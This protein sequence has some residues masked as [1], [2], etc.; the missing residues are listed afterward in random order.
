MKFKHLALCPVFLLLVACSNAPHRAK[1]SLAQQTT[2]PEQ[3]QEQ[4]VANDDAVNGKLTD[5][6]PLAE[7]QQLVDSGL[8]ANPNL[9]QTA[10]ALSIAQA[11][12]DVSRAGQLPQLELSLKQ[13][14]Q[15]QQA[16]SYSAGLSL[17]WTVDIWQQLRDNKL[18]SKAQLAGAAATYQGARDL[19]AAN[20]ING[21]LLLIKEQQLIETE[22]AKLQV[23]E[24]NEQA[25][26]ERYRQGL[27]TLSE[28]DTARSNTES[29]RA[30]LVALTENLQVAKR[31]LKLLLGGKLPELSL[32]G[33]FPEVLLP[34]SQLPEQDLAR[35]PDLQQAYQ[36]IL[37]SE[38]QADVAYKALLPQL[39]LQASLSDSNGRL[40]QA[41]FKDPLWSLLSGITAP[42]F[43]GGKLKAQAEIAELTAEQ[44]YWAYQS[45]LLTAVNEVE[46]A[47]AQERALQQQQQHIQLALENAQ[48]SSAIYTEKYRQGLVTLLDLLQV[49]QQ[50]F[51][52]QSQLTQLVYQGLTNRINLGLALGLGV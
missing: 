20:I 15:Q 8:Q 45:T 17:S 26:V 18:A 2:I 23:L 4:L 50:T 6:L 16:S 34:L 42:L 41:L 33:D 43:Q 35:R 32:G 31:S 29:S 14:K 21:W 25:V 40:S 10:L 3:W 1:G 49:Q 47:L 7:L 51:S 36:A 12:V 28:L 27:G 5:L 11:N 22:Q 9:Q 13:Q 44:S 38:Y 52:L 39:N 46:N 24:Q 19:L 48:R 37:A 30:N